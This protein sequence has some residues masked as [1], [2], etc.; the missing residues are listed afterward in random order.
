[1]Y[2]TD[3]KVTRI[4]KEKTKRKLPVTAVL[5]PA[6]LT[7]QVLA[8]LVPGFAEW[9]AVT[10][11]PWLLYV[12]GGIS[13]PFPF[14]LDECLIY[15]LISSAAFYVF[16]GICSIWKKKVSLKRWCLT[17]LGL[18]WKAGVWWLFLFTV[19]CGINYHRTPFSKLAELPME[20][21]TVEELEE[22]CLWLTGQIEEAGSRVKVQDDGLTALPEDMREKTLDAMTE[23][24]ERWPELG[25]W[26]PKAK[27]V[28]A[29]KVLSLEF[30]EGVFGPYTMEAHYNPDIPAYNQPA[31]LCHEL[32]HLQGFMREDEANYIAYLACTG[33][34]DP[35]LNYSGLLLAYTHSINALYR[36]DP[37]RF[38]V[39]RRQL[40]EQAERDYAWHRE[41]WAQYEGPVSEL[42]DKVNDTYL[43]ANAQQE[44][45]KSYGR[46]VDLLLGEHR[47]RKEALTDQAAGAGTA[48][49]LD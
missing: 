8:R 23:L 9:Y 48:L 41:Y 27:P 33:S 38:A 5:L 11:Y 16:W 34:D 24:G 40:C 21:S 43:R 13:S 3:E 7:L 28:F 26:Y 4:E 22:L 46:M 44:G 18:V 6:A 10:V 17:S 45:S 32:S 37:E 1:M 25:G 47:Q 20:P 14:A 36:A 15:L 39:V 19:T 35:N 49:P 2:R 42:S 30:L 29:W 12:L 31:V